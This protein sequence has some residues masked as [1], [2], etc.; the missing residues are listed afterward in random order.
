MK[1]LSIYLF[2]AHLSFKFVYLSLKFMG[3]MMDYLIKGQSF[4][5]LQ[6]YGFKFGVMLVYPTFRTDH[7][8]VILCW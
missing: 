7:I 6:T 1:I 8:V 3:S 5:T 4:F 2:I